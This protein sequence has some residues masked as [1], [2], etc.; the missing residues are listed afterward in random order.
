MLNEL[1]TEYPTA[2]KEKLEKVLSCAYALASPE[3]VE[4]GLH[5]FPIENIPMAAKLIVSL[6]NIFLIVCCQIG[7]GFI[8]SFYSTTI[9]L[10]HQ[11]A[12]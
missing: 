10:Y 11:I 2:P 4:L 8:S 9:H 3:S 12:C 5:S 6:T 1:I 7:Q